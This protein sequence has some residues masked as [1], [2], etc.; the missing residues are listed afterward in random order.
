LAM[1]F[2][3]LS[4]S[5]VFVS[6]GWETWTPD[7]DFD[8]LLGIRLLMVLF[9][10]IAIALSL[11]CLYFYPFTKSKVDGIKSQLKELHEKKLETVRSK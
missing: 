10:I 6:T 5:L 9:P 8:I 3:V 2:S 7:P 11:V 1:V 4:V